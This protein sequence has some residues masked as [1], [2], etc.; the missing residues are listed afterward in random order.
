M[1]EDDDRPICLKDNVRDRTERE[2]ED[3]WLL[4]LCVWREREKKKKRT[5]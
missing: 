5:G 4:Y 1:S 2:R 3:M